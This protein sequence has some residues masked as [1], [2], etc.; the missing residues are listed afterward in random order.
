MKPRQSIN[1]EANPIP[2]LYKTFCHLM[3][4][5]QLLPNTGE[6]DVQPIVPIFRSCIMILV[7][8]PGKL[9]K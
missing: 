8:I 5:T 1:I 4:S 2:I 6:F 9:Y 3:E 7:E